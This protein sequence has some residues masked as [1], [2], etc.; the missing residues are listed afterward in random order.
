MHLLLPLYTH[1]HAYA[2]AEAHAYIY[3]S[4]LKE[5]G[6]FRPEKGKG[7]FILALGK[8]ALRPEDGGLLAIY[9]VILILLTVC[10]ALICVGS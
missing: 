5:R 8:G 9:F 4:I 10:Y 1:T 2:H 3:I 7:V 6:F